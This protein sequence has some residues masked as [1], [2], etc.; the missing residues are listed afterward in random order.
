MLMRLLFRIELK[1][2]VAKYVFTSLNCSDPQARSDPAGGSE[3]KLGDARLILFI[4]LFIKFSFSKISRLESLAQ[5]NGG[6]EPE[7]SLL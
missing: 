1:I 7:P 4:H 2:V 3:P 5:P 6:S